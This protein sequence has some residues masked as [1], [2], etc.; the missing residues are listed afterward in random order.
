MN[1]NNNNGD[2]EADDTIEDDDTEINYTA[3]DHREERYCLWSAFKKMTY[4][5]IM[6]SLSKNYVLRQL[7][8]IWLHLFM[9]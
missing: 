7:S 4:K 5:L 9:I 3:K 2:D 8:M 6:F 1:C